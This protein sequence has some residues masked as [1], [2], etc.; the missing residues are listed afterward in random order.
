MI[1]ASFGPFQVDWS[2]YFGALARA[3]LVTVE[4]TVV[5]FV[6]ASLGG[7]VLA[8]LR[9]SHV[10][11]IR[12]ISYTYTEIFKNLP[13]ITLIFIVYFGLTAIGIRFGAFAAGVICLALFYS[14]YLSEVFRGG[15]QGVPPGQRE[16]GQAVGFNSTRVFFSVSLPQVV[17]LALPGTATMLVDL[18]K[19]TALLVTIGGGE[20]MTEGTIITA[21]TFRALEVYIVIGAIYLVLCWPLSRLSGYLERHLRLNRPLSVRRLRVRRLALSELSEG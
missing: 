11:A 14:A 20:L 6:L 19:G 2:S 8:I 1:V 16:A 12:A 15:I 17:A 21:N 10:R 9:T 18:L 7:M 5:S 3:L 13:L 4:L